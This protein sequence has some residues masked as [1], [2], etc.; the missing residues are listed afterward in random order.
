MPLRVDGP[1][2]V[3]KA[4]K[5]AIARVQ[6]RPAPKVPSRPR[7]Y[8]APRAAAPVAVAR[9]RAP[10][11]PTSK[12]DK[13]LLERAAG[14]AGGLI[15]QVGELDLVPV[16][17]GGSQR[18]GNQFGGQM[19]SQQVKPAKV[20]HAVEAVGEYSGIQS[21]RRI[22]NG[23]GS[24]ADYLA[25]AA[26]AAPSFLRPAV[27]GARAGRTVGIVSPGMAKSISA[28][29]YGGVKIKPSKKIGQMEQE[30]IR[31]NPENPMRP[32]HGSRPLPK[33]PAQ[34]KR[35]GVYR[36]PSPE[37]DYQEYMGNRLHWLVDTENDQVFIGQPGQIHADIYTAL[38]ER[39]IMRDRGR[40]GQGFL[41]DNSDEWGYAGSHGG[42]EWPADLV[43]TSAGPTPALNHWL[44]L[45]TRNLD[46]Y[47][48]D[49]DLGMGAPAPSAG[50]AHGRLG[51]ASDD[52]PDHSLQR[53]LMR[54]RHLRQRYD[55]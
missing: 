35:G 46:I 3:T 19:R 30:R 29:R 11:A 39:G 12:R 38:A 13:G 5:K 40:L 26:V 15:R 24:W 10:L 27:A 14:A 42:D 23:E 17:F 9:P 16:G 54:M 37:E 6:R 20:K 18:S 47:D 28:K 41:S 2:I 50:S 45:L 32:T 55:R 8:V 44:A 52:F 21:A 31:V 33:D 22:R 48:D 53:A 25:V 1:D 43:A 7:A 4:D 49:I 36:V 34:L 51:P